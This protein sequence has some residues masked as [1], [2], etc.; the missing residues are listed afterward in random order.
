MFEQGAGKLDLLRTYQTLST[1]TPQ[2]SLSSSYVDTTECQYFW[3]Y[4]TQPMFHTSLPTFINVTILNGIGV[5][6]WVMVGPP[7]Y[8]PPLHPRL[9]P[10]SG[11]IRHALPSHLAL[12]WLSRL[13]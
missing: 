4:C 6:G 1:Y 3:P 12:G 2:V 10:L 7:S 9:G 5:S 11:Y 8:H 13:R